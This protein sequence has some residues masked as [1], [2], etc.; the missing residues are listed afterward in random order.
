MFY[1]QLVAG[2]I[3]R[4]QNLI[5]QFYE[6]HVWDTDRVK[7]GLLQ[8]M[9]GFFKKVVI[10]DSCATYANAVF[11]KKES[12]KSPIKKDSAASLPVLKNWTK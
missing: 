12:K 1:Q 6:K 5:H 11:E 10:A 3:E 7:I 9:Q 2:P 8:M 4:P